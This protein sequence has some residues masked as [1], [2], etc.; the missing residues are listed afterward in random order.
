LPIE[1]LAAVLIRF[2]VDLRFN[3]FQILSAFIEVN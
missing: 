3:P 2:Y 1:G